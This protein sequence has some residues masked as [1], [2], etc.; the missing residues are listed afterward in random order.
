[1]WLWHGW[2][3]RSFSAVLSWHLPWFSYL[4]FA[5]SFTNHKCHMP[6]ALWTLTSPWRNYLPWVW[7]LLRCTTVFYGWLITL[8]SHL[9]QSWQEEKLGRVLGEYAHSPKVCS[10]SPVN[11]G[12]VSRGHAIHIW[13][14]WGHHGIFPTPASSLAPKVFC[15]F[16]VFSLPLVSPSLILIFDLSTICPL[17]G[18]KF[19]FS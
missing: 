6:P 13:P 15:S 5:S 10:E 4:G 9:T 12:E 19:Y 17:R 8:G 1:M 11:S 3:L 2:S 7:H 14:D 16:P 18:T